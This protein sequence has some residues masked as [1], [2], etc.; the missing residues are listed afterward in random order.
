MSIDVT[1]CDTCG[2]A[3]LSC[4]LHTCKD[5]LGS[6][7]NY[8]SQVLGHKP[9]PHKHAAL[10]KA[11]ADGADIEFYCESSLEWVGTRNPNWN[12]DNQYRIKPQPHKWQKEIDAFKAGKKIQYLCSGTWM[13]LNAP[14]F[15][16]GWE[17]RIKPD[18]VTYRMFW[19]KPGTLGGDTIKLGMVTREENDGEDRCTWSGFICW[20]S[21]WITV[22]QP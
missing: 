18:S 14:S 6:H 12:P 19:W 5:P 21:D 10:I 8:T 3:V 9:Q 15:S 11:W 16:V 20:A 13:D 22:E 7:L 4:A 17:Y 2:K 1:H